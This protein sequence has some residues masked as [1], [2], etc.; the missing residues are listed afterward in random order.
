M[1][2]AFTLAILA[3]GASRR[4]GRDKAAL[5]AGDGPLLER[6][7]R[8]GLG[9]GLPVLV[10]GRERPAGWPLPEVRFV[11][12]RVPGQGP[13]GGLVTALELASPLLAIACD[14][15]RL[16]DECL[17]WLLAEGTRLPLADGLITTD[18]GGIEP[19]FAC[20]SAHCLTTARAHLAAGQ[21]AMH[22]L[23]E[24][25]DFRRVAIPAHLLPRLADVDTP[26]DWDRA[27]TPPRA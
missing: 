3:G 13:L 15:P 21:R 25:G 4:M 27:R 5:D 20:Y 26:E 12:D 16:D 24:A 9:L 22:R 18:T 10:V 19:L 23:V 7:A 11:T 6:C 2:Q 14:L 8:L 17:R 1:G